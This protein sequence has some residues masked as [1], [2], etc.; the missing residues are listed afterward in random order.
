MGMV[1]DIARSSRRKV[2]AAA[3]HI[4]AAKAER[5]SYLER[6]LMAGADALIEADAEIAGLAA[7]NSALRLALEHA[8][9]KLS[10]SHEG[11][12]TRK[13]HQAKLVNTTSGGYRE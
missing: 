5:G 9:A 2:L 7:Q 1:V 6:D 10:E 4:H 13:S 11:A 8:D 12:K 3:L